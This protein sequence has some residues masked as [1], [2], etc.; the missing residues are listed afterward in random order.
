MSDRPPIRPDS[1]IRIRPLTR[2]DADIY[3]SLVDA[4][5]DFEQMDRP[6][7]EARERLVG[8]ALS[9]PPR[10]RAYLAT[11]EGRDVGYA[12]TYLAYSSFLARPTF[13][14]ED[15]FVFSEYRGR[16]FG[17]AMFQY[18]VREAVRLECGRM[19]WMVQEWNEGAI[20]FYERRGAEEL[21]EWRT[22]RIDQEQLARLGAAEA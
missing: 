21:S 17:G 16:G 15:I 14:L 18:L 9:D 13:F 3:L 5:A 12:I 1:D 10:Y 20:R 4:H 6:T 8:D 22:Y 7:P 2:A 19:E 11:I